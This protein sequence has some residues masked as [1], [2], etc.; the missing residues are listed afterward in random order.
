MW[1]CV[2]EVFGEQCVVICGEEEKQLLFA[3]NW[4]TLVQVYCLVTLCEKFYFG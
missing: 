4:D 2:S 3:D 1:K